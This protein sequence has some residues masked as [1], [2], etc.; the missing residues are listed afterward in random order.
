MLQVFFS[1][2]FL[3]KKLKNSSIL[4]VFVTTK[5]PKTSKNLMHTM[6]RTL[7]IITKHVKI[8]EHQINERTHKTV[9]YKNGQVGPLN[10]SLY[11]F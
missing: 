7:F 6:T 3:F 8:T 1:V 11:L 4:L 9:M 5:S 2:L 10:R